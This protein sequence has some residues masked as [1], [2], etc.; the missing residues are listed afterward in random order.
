MRAQ[1]ATQFALDLCK[2]TP[3]LVTA[4]SHTLGPDQSSRPARWNVNVHFIF[5]Q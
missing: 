1:I 5:C 2:G 3:G 4:I